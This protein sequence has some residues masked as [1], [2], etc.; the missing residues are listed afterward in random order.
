MFLYVSET[1]K[2]RASIYFY[3]VWLKCTFNFVMEHPGMS[4]F[5]GSEGLHLDTMFST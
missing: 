3:K 2:T 5:E 4:I 1:H